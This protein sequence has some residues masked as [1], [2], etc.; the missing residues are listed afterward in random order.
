MNSTGQDA[1]PR[2]DD[3]Y[4]LH[5]DDSDKWTIWV[6]DAGRY[7]EYQDTHIEHLEAVNRNLR[8]SC[9][10]LKKLDAEKIEEIAR[11]EALNIS[12]EHERDAVRAEQDRADREVTH[13]KAE[14][15]VAKNARKRLE[16][17][18]ERLKEHVHELHVRYM[19][20]GESDGSQC[21]TC[22]EYSDACD[23]VCAIEER[24]GAPAEE[25]DEAT[26]GIE[27]LWPEEGGA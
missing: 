22:D 21:D 11:L 14:L 2:P 9:E 6:E 12:L 18:N 25:P 5:F 10:I 4:K 7:M 3:Y 20:E 19:E 23:C 15:K 27:M 16:A 13:T 8:E 24:E 26:T 1:P 17:E